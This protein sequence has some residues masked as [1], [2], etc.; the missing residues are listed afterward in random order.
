LFQFRRFS[1]GTKEPGQ[2]MLSGGGCLGHSKD[3]DCRRSY[4]PFG[5]Y[6]WHTVFAFKFPHRLLPRPM[7]STEELSELL[8]T[9]YAAPLQ[10]DKWQIFFDH[11]SRLTKISSGYLMTG[12]EI[13]GYEA[14]AG[15][16]LAFNPETVR[17]YN[18]YY[19]RVDPFAAPA[20]RN[21]HVAVIRGEELVDQHQLLRTELYNDLLRGNEMES[22][23]LLSCNSRTDR[24]DVMPVWRRKQDGP[25]D[26]VSIALLETLLP[27]A[28]TALEIRR[29]LQAANAQRHFAELALDAMS[30]AAFLVTATGHVQ[31]MNQRAAALVEKGDGL[32]L[33]GTALTASNSTECAR[34][35]SFISGAAS[36]GRS[37]THIAP[38]GALNISRQ[39]TQRSLHLTVLPVPEDRRSMVTI[40]CALVLVSDPSVSPKSR[41]AFM[42]MLYGLTPTESR[43]ADLLLEGL[44]VRG[45]ADRLG[46]TIET[47]RFHLKRVLAKT[48]TRRQTELM[49]LMLSLPGE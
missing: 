36:A 34:L 38:G 11:L 9:L 19:V 45:T 47:A 10:P 15:G 2:T 43:L 42:R 20:L 26:E 49:R 33:E 17:L 46:I 29:G 27:H 3:Q 22:M 24:V 12:D 35:R 4:L 23:T 48:G 1:T 32:R 14:L 16:G 21:P 13:Q 7:I 5:R 39:E 31:H 37:G 6:L 41:A 30:T 8:A 18:E 25:M 44:E 28:L 40:P